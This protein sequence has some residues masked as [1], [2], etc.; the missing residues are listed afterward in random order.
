MPVQNVSCSGGLNV[1]SPIYDLK[2]GEAVALLNVEV[3]T[4]G[5]Y[6]TMAGC[7]KFDGR[8]EPNKATYR[9]MT[10]SAAAGI[11]LG[12][13]IVAAPS[14]W[15]AKVIGIDGN[16]VGVINE[17][18]TLTLS[19]IIAGNAVLSLPTEFEA[20]S[21]ATHKSFR[22]RT[23][24]SFR[25]LIQPVPGVG[26]VRGVVIYKGNVYAFRDHSDLTTCRMY[27][28]SLSGWVEV[29]TSGF[30]LKNGRYKFR[31][32]NFTAG[33]GTQKL[34]ITNGVNKACTYD[35]TTVVQIS[36]AMPTDIPGSVEVL[37]SSVLLLGY[38]NGSLMT[39][40]IGDPYDF[41][42]GSGGTELGM[43]DEIVDLSLQPDGKVAIF[44]K[45]SIKIL[46]GKTTATFDLST[47]NKDSGAVNGSVVN[48][49]DSI[50]L[51]QSGLTRLARSQVYGAFEMVGIDKKIRRLLNNDDVFFSVAVHRKNQYRIFSSAGFVG[52]T[53]AGSDVV[54]A[55]VGSYPAKMK[56]GFSGEI[57]SEEYVLMGG[58]DGFVYR[59]DVGQ[60]HAGESF[61][62]VSRMAYNDLKTGQQRKKFKRLVINAD[63]E[64]L[65]EVKI[66]VDIDYS[67][68]DAP[69]QNPYVIFAGG[70]EIYLG[71]A[72]LGQAV[73]GDAS[74]AINQ[75]YL[76]G[77]GR[78][79][80]V[81]ALLNSDSADPVRFGGY[82][83]EYEMRAK[84]R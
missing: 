36:T 8:I 28:S 58:E 37:P 39:S 11:T 20:R 9:Y 81:S 53:L 47:F 54:G 2:P 42:V 74:D 6:T 3:D 65:V 31:I 75:I 66:S 27:R 60:S 50:F 33:A 45:N 55:F 72:I 62:R 64:R 77:V 79:L 43:S 25:A 57:N 21:Y 18:G 76:S 35:G 17:T 63:S 84:T 15:S 5:S 71:T 49:G 23:Q 19:D 69:R 40:K 26:E 41:T 73:F 46:S 24:E 44:C 48:I 12:S 38:A 1:E 7:E 52:V 56:C 16:A 68:G 10:L 70:S 32:H 30:L 22:K 51:S 83:I 82:S 14:G 80:S 67:S 59:A 78:S 34:I 61:T 13:T 4:S 29:P